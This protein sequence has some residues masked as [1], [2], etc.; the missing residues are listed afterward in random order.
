MRIQLY[1]HECYQALLSSNIQAQIPRPIWVCD[2]SGLGLKL[3]SSIRNPKKNPDKPSWLVGL[4]SE[5]CRTASV[6]QAIR[7]TDS[8][9]NLVGPRPLGIIVDNGMLS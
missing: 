3:S 6:V 8:V 4:A 1:S 7:A 5:A 2:R 9:R